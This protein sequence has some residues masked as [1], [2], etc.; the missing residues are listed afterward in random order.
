MSNQE[1]LIPIEESY[2]VIPGRFRAGEY[3]G[4]RE[5]GQARQ[6]LR[7]LLGQ[8]TDVFVDLTDEGEAGLHPYLHVLKEE[9]DRS[10]QVVHHRRMALRDFSTPGREQVAEILDTIDLAL[11]LGKNIYLHCYGGKG[12][13][14]TVVGCFLARHGLSGQQA[15][16]RIL[17]LRSRIPGRDEP[18]PETE[19][20]KR[21]VLE[22]KAG[23]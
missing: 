9:S 2:W 6:K 4:A 15:L 1:P 7:W 22:W 13:T 20:Q 21:M 11:S 23:Q 19:G 12:R 16:D 18:S 14:G 5:D 3:P 10:G 17:L 8:D